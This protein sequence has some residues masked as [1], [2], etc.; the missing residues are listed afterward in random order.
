MK[1]IVERLKDKVNNEYVIVKNYDNNEYYLLLKYRKKYTNSYPY[2][3]EVKGMR[4]IKT[5]IINN[6]L[7]IITNKCYDKESKEVKHGKNR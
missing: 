1:K 4:N 7:E 3:V 6:K 2:K 5:F